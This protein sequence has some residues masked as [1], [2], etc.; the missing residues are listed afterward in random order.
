MRPKSESS[1]RASELVRMRLRRVRKCCTALDAEKVSLGATSVIDESPTLFIIS[2]SVWLILREDI[3]GVPFEPVCVDVSG[4]PD[5]VLEELVAVLI[6]HNDASGLDDFVDI[7]NELATFGTKLLLFNKG[8][9][10]D[11]VQHVVDLSVV[12][13]PPITEGLNDAVESNLD[14]VGKVQSADTG[15]VVGCV[16]LPCDRCLQPGRPCSLAP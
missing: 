10:E 7:L 11:I 9:V 3:F 12:G 8:M 1:L 5:E 6:L 14:I 4:I 13:H 16:D 2:S 15:K